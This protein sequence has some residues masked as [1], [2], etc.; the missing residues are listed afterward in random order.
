MGAWRASEGDAHLW[1]FVSKEVSPPQP[2]RYPV[3]V[4]SGQARERSCP[5]VP[6]L[7]RTCL[8]GEFSAV[9]LGEIR[10][11]PMGREDGV[12]AGTRVR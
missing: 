4:F 10:I 1:S 11:L 3:L 8:G 6:R 12:A 5:I 7:I 9:T 2:F